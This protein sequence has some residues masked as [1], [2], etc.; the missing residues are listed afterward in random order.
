MPYVK[1]GPR[2]QITI[3]R[4]VREAAG[5]DAGDLLE[6]VTQRGKIVII[7]KQIVSRPVAMKL[8]RNEQQI[9]L[10][11]KKKIKAIQDDMVN[12]TGLSRAEVD[13]AAKV[14]LIAQDQRWWWLEEWQEGEREVERDYAEGNVE[15]FDNAEDF[16]NS[17]PS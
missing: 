14:G 4:E 2:H 16:L 11:A 15:V 6:I 8:S 5:I 12:S 9:L 1:V 7:P 17:L 3:P 13:V 10:S